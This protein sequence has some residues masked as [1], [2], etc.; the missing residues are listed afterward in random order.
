MYINMYLVKVGMVEPEKTSVAGQRLG[1]HVPAKT[2]NNEGV[3]GR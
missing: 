3:V 2:N 1:N